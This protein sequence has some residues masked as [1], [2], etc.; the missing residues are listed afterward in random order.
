[1]ISDSALEA[2]IWMTEFEKKEDF[3]LEDELIAREGDE[4]VALR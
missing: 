1:V 4:G 3:S 2:A